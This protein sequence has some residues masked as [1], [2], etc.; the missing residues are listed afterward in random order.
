MTNQVHILYMED[1]E[2]TARLLEKRLV[3][4]GYLVDTV[5]DGEKGVELCATQIYDVIIV[6]YDMPGLNG[7]QVIQHLHRREIKSPIIM[8]TGSGNERVAVEALKLGASDYM[9]KDING[10]YFDLLPNIIDQA[11]KNQQLLAEKQYAEAALRESEERFRMLFEKA[12]NPYFVSDMEGNLLNC[13]KAVEPLV[14][15]PIEELIG[16]HFTEM[17]FLNEAQLNQIAK[18]LFEMS[19]NVFSDAVEL[20]LI[21]P[22]GKTVVVD[23]RMIPMRTEGETRILGMGHDVTWRKQA[24]TQMKAHIRQLETLSRIDEALTRKLDINYVQ[25]MALDHMMALSNANAGSIALLDEFQAS[26]FQSIGYP[27]AY[28]QQYTLD[29][30]SIQTRVARKREAEWI[31]DVT[32]DADYLPVLDNICSQ[33]TLPLVSQERLVGIINLVS[34]QPATFN[35]ELFELLKLIAARMAVAIDNAQLYDAGQRQLTELQ[36]LYRQV[37]ELEQLKTD[38]IR[39]AAHDLRNPLTSVLTKTY[40]LQKILDDR[41]TLKERNYLDSINVNVEQ[42]QALINDFLSVERIEKTVQDEF[43]GKEVNLKHVVQR[44]IANYQPELEEKKLDCRFSACHESLV[45][46][47]FEIELQQAIA[48]L[49][50]NS[51]KYTPVGGFIDISL[52]AQEANV[53]FQVTDSGHGIPIEQQRNLFQPFF[54]VQVDETQSIKGTGLGLYLV[55]K[56][57]ERNS[58]EVIFQSEYGK[59]STFGFVLPLI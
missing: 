36:S 4:A 45:V 48:N 38:M 56:V 2:G 12:P 51:I 22:D 1:N 18:I 8:L 30:H 35:A 32:K 25:N 10:V 39:L 29:D 6:D 55:K 40:L 20:E 27:E 19:E 46:K 44:V 9:V 42:M 43:E 34:D 57:I 59:G 58:G 28:K 53:R 49:I 31:V 23:L 7:L 3:R 41:L 17:A 21:G 15:K 14:G 16:T 13:N 37:S 47:G 5:S 52:Q 24:E 50:G 54:R 33:I 11:L 26:S